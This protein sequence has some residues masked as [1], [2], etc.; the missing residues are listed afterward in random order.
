MMRPLGRRTLIAGAALLGLPARAQPGPGGVVGGQPMPAVP[1]GGLVGPG[2]LPGPTLEL[3]FQN[4]L[5][6]DPRISFTRA[7]SGTYF[8]VTGT[9]QTAA[10]NVPR[11]G[12]DPVSHL[13]Q[14]LLIEEQRTNALSNPRAEGI[15]PG[16]L[17]SG[18]A[19]PTTWARVNVV[20]G[21]TL[22]IA[23][24]T[25]QG[26]SGLRATYSGTTS[27]GGQETFEFQSRTAVAATQSQTWTGSFYWVVSSGAL[28]AGVTVVSRILSLTSTTAIVDN[29]QSSVF[30][31]T[32][33]LQRSAQTLTLAANA[34][35]TNVINGIYLGN[36]PASTV[37]NFS[38]DIFAPQLELG[39]FATSVMLPTVGSPAASTRAADT[40][41][42]PLGSWF[43]PVQWSWAVEAQPMMQATLTGVN[44][45]VIGE[46]TTNAGPVYIA[47]SLKGGTFDG[48]SIINTGNT[49]VMGAVIKLGSTFANLIGT[50]SLNGGTP[51]S[52][53]Q[54]AKA[55]T[56]AGYRFGNDGS[57][58]IMTGYLRRVR[59]W[60][61]ALSAGELQIV[62]T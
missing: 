4:G 57:N 21:V 22:T 31:S 25:N 46:S 53:A 32:G 17:G 44:P 28:P 60:P 39:A 18:G 48:S 45:R 9:M 26:M 10:S 47:S 14:G 33:V 43:N 62:T 41:M 36:W 61:R 58:D 23:P 16:V 8:D 12:Y 50:T 19:L 29:A 51:V 5:G 49:F 42:M 55:L 40:A 24:I 56:A 13:I 52:G 34:T 3:D 20:S 54:V 11:I 7:S 38:I 35:I 59:Y 2:G 30:P 6:L 1:G 37:V 27:G 15:T